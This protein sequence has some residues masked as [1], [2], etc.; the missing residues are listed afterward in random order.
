M[1]LV[2]FWHNV[3]GRPNLKALTVFDFRD[4]S[5]PSSLVL[6]HA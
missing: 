3:L 4:D 1:C 6:N 2:L 5:I